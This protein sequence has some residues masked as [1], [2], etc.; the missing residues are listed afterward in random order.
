MRSALPRALLVLFL[1]V[2]LL[3]GAAEPPPEPDGYR[4]D[5]YRAPTPATLAG[6][7]VLGTAEAERLWREGSAVFV[8]VFPRP[9]RPADLPPGT[10]WRDKRRESIPGSTWLPNVGYGALSEDKERYFRRSLDEIADGNVGRRLVFYCEAECWMS[11]NAAKR[12]LAFG[13]AN[14]AWYP[15]GTDGWAGAGLPLAEVMPRP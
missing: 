10:L 2:P 6:A 3:A 9:V 13:Y 8:D 14:V 12:A 1:A 15:D 4:M 11:W 5:D 7:D